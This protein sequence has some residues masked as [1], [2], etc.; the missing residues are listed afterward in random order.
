MRAADDLDVDLAE[1]LD[2]VVLD[3]LAEAFAFVD[4][5][6]AYYRKGAG[7]F[8]WVLEKPV[9]GI[10]VWLKGLTYESIPGKLQWFMR[11]PLVASAIIGQSIQAFFMDSTEQKALPRYMVEICRC[12]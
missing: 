3:F 7:A 4:F 5:Y 6:A 10:L 1:R 12:T 11:N 2:F 9:Q 8:M